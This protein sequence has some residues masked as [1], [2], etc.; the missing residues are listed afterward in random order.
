MKIKIKKIVTGVH[1]E[2]GVI[3]YLDKL[4]QDGLTN[5]SMVINQIVKEHA[6]TKGITIPTYT[7]ER[8]RPS[9]YHS[10][11]AKQG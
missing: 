4:T 9:P 1:F 10:Q 6:L 2:Q 11:E 8:R 7:E 3:E 5:R